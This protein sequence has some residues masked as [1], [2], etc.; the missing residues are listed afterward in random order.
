MDDQ[1]QPGSQKH[2][3][4]QRKSFQEKYREIRQPHI[5]E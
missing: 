4:E 1:L 5:T 3:T 2:T